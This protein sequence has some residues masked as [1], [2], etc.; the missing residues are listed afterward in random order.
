MWRSGKTA[1]REE[2]DGSLSPTM[3]SIPGVGK[4][5]PE[6]S[7]RMALIW[8]IGCLPQFIVF[9]A[10]ALGDVDRGESRNG[11]D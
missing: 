2:V 5:V 11:I 7:G 6:E 9:N 3:P 10:S 8:Y 4:L 1:L